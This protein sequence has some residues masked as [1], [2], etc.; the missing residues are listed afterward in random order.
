MTGQIRDR[1]RMRQVK[2]FHGHR[3]GS[4]SPTD[5]DAFL[6]F[7]DQLCVFVETKHVRAN[8]SHGQLLA[9]ERLC[10][11]CQSEQ[12]DAVVVI[13]R[14]ETDG[15]ID[16]AATR[17][18]RFFHGDAWYR[19]HPSWTLREAIDLFWANVERGAQLVDGAPLR[20]GDGRIGI[21]RG[22]PAGALAMLGDRLR[23]GDGV[24]LRVPPEGRRRRRRL[25]HS[26]LG[27]RSPRC[28]PA[29]RSPVTDRPLSAHR[30]PRAPAASR[31]SHTRAGTPDT[32]PDACGGSP[33][34]SLPPR[35]RDRPGARA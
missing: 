34:G 15:D 3:Y 2:L 21:G 25:L 27:F 8:P 30:S 28:G 7:G 29:D 22:L 14:H 10:A 35:R 16:L 11:G 17:V 32:G 13:T 18:E 26:G 20:T 5:V 33:G 19:T 1:D 4:I 6:D 12:R 9:L 23:G 31:P 24:R